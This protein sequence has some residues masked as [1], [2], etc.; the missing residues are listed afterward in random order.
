MSSFSILQFGNISNR[1]NNMFKQLTI[2]IVYTYI[3]YCNK[4]AI[5]SINVLN[6]VC[7][8]GESICTNINTNT[9]TKD[10]VKRYDLYVMF[11]ERHLKFGNQPSDISCIFEYVQ[12]TIDDCIDN[13]LSFQ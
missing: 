3:R 1:E 11:S 8:L 5:Q 7:N 6:R 13:V 4:P 2:I 10:D 12:Y 9:H